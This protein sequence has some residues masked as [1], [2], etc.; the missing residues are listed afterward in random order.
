[1][2]IDLAEQSSAIATIPAELAAEI[3]DLLWG[4]ERGMIP[5]AV[6]H[7]YEAIWQDLLIGGHRP[8]DRLSDVDW[9]AKLGLSRTPVRQALH[10]LAQDELVRFDPR[11]GFWVREFTAGDIH[12]LYDVRAALEALALRLAAPHLSPADVQ[13]HLDQIAAL[14]ARLAERPVVPCLLHDFQLHN[15]I[16][17]GSRNG[18]LIRMLAALRSQTSHFQ[19]RDTGYPNR[20]K[21]ALDGHELVLRALIEGETEAAAHHLANHIATA[22]AAVLHDMFA[23]EEV[24]PTAESLV[25]ELVP[26]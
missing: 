26:A 14:T 9:S 25:P 1:M 4:P 17:R 7:A 15:F 24:M 6:D 16:I 20:L 10:R 18:R 22:K 13:L 21:M 8:G 3:F 12:E 2:T 5:T 11:R 23:L 19:V